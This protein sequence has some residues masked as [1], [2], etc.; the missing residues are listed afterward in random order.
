MYDMEVEV[1]LLIEYANFV[2]ELEYANEN[3]TYHRK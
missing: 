3:V 2:S 1:I